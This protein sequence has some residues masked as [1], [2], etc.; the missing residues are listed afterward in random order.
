MCISESEIKRRKAR[1]KR[2]G[3][4]KS[5]SIS[6]PSPSLD[7]STISFKIEHLKE[8]VASEIQLPS[9]SSLAIEIKTECTNAQPDPHPHAITTVDDKEC[10]CQV[11]LDGHNRF[12]VLYNR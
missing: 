5:Q 4:P 7:E 1:R 8:E 10:F 6:T 12:N 9:S 11:F 3:K 2:W